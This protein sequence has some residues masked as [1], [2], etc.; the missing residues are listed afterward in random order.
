MRSAAQAQGDRQPDP[1]APPA[2]TIGHDD[3]AEAKPLETAWDTGR[4]FASPAV[5][6]TAPNTSASPAASRR[7]GTKR[8]LCA[9]DRRPRRRHRSRHQRVAGASRKTAAP[10][11]ACVVNKWTPFEKDSPHHAAMEEGSCAA[12]ASISSIGRDAVHL[13][14]QRPAGWRGIFALPCWR[15]AAPGVD[16]HHL[17]VNE[18]LAGGAELALGPHQP[19]RSSRAP[20]TPL[21]RHPGA[22]PAPQLHA[23]SVNAFRKLF[24]ETLPALC[25]NARSAEGLRLRWAR[26]SS[27]FLAWQS[28]NGLR[29]RSS[30]A[31]GPR[32]RPRRFPFRFP[33]RGPLPGAIPRLVATADLA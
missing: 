16:G 9:G 6:A 18:V 19:R 27:C 12:K 4:A 20:G 33:F 7:C 22:T 25:W 17:G 2:T 21:L 24:G 15:G 5:S 10:A 28:R 31:A 11:F 23:D 29:R 13:R 32:H 14:P 1:V 26:R 8:C 30:T 3:R